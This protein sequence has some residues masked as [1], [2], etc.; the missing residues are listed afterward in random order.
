MCFIELF[1]AGLF[2]VAFIVLYIIIG[3]NDLWWVVLVIEGI[4]ALFIVISLLKNKKE[5]KNEVKETKP[6]TENAAK[7]CGVDWNEQAVMAAKRCIESK[8]FSRKKLI[9]QLI[10]DGFTPEQAEYA[11]D[12][13]ER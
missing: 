8:P 12:A 11:A 9:E 1:F 7:N 2:I 5:N 10:D 4:I 3:V 6:P 13:I